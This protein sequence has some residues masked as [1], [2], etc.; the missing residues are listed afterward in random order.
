MVNLIKDLWL[1]LLLILGASLLLLLSDL[2]Q[3]KGRKKDIDQKRFPSI[4][5]MQIRSTPL[6]DNHVAGITDRLKQLGFIAPDKQ[7]IRIFNHQGDLATANTIAMEIVNG[8]YELVITSST[9]SLQTFAKANQTTGKLH[10]FGAV[11]DPYGTGVGIKGAEPGQHPPYMAVIGTFQPF[12]R[13]FQV[14]C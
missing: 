5:I 1:A 14:M 12:R 11:T 6:L 3:R 7:N 8:P 4:A 13:A 10:V 2:E 9:L